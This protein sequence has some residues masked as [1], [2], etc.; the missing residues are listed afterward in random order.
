MDASEAETKIYEAGFKKEKAEKIQNHG[1]VILNNKLLPAS[2]INDDQQTA[3]LLFSDAPDLYQEEVTPEAEEQCLIED[4]LDDATTISLLGVAANNQDTPSELVKYVRKMKEIHETPCLIQ[5]PAT[6]DQTDPQSTQIQHILSPEKTM[7]S[8]FSLSLRIL[9]LIILASIKWKRSI[10]QNLVLCKF[11]T[12]LTSGLLRP[13]GLENLLPMI[14]EKSSIKEISHDWLRSLNP[15]LAFSGQGPAWQNICKAWDTC[16]NKDVLET[17]QDLCLTNRDAGNRLS[18]LYRKDLPSFIRR[19]P[20]MKFVIRKFSLILN[21]IQITNL[22]DQTKDIQRVTSALIVMEQLQSDFFVKK[23]GNSY[24][25]YFILRD[26]IKCYKYLIGTP[27]LKSLFKE[28][29]ENRNHWLPANLLDKGLQ[30]NPSANIFNQEPD[31]HTAIYR[32]IPHN[33][34]IIDCIQTELDFTDSFRC[35]SVF[36]SYILSHELKLTFPSSFIQRMTIQNV[37]LPGIYF[38]RSRFHNFR[39]NLSSH[40]KN[41]RDFLISQGINPCPL[42]IS[43]FSSLAYSFTNE[44]HQTV[45]A[46]PRQ[47][48]LG[49]H[50][51]Y[52]KIYLELESVVRILQLKKLVKY[53]RKS[54]LQC[55]KQL[56]QTLPDHPGKTPEH[57]ILRMNSFNSAIMVDLLP[58]IKI[59]TTINKKSTRNATVLNCH[60]LLGVDVATKFSSFVIINSR[61]S[62]DI[63]NGLSALC[64]KIGKKAT[65]FFSDRESSIVSLADN[66]RWIK[67]SNGIYA[68]DIIIRF[69]PALAESHSRAGLVE[70]RVGAIKRSLGSLD[71][72]SFNLVDLNI[73]LEMLFC[74]LNSIPIYSK[75]LASK[76]HIF[77]NIYTK[78]INPNQLQGR[79][80]LFF[81]DSDSSETMLE[82]RKLYTEMID[83]TAWKTWVI[84][85]RDTDLL[86]QKVEELKIGSIVLFRKTE[87][88]FGPTN[89]FF[90]GVLVSIS[91]PSSDGVSRS[92]YIQSYVE[93]DQIHDSLEEKELPRLYIY[94]RKISDVILIENQEEKLAK[95]ELLKPKPNDNAKEASPASTNHPREE[96]IQTERRIMTRSRRKNEG[97]ALSILLVLNKTELSAAMYTNP[98]IVSENT[99]FDYVQIILYLLLV[100]GIAF[101]LLHHMVKKY[102]LNTFTDTNKNQRIKSFLSTSI[103]RSCSDFLTRSRATPYKNLYTIPLCVILH[104]TCTALGFDKL[105]IPSRKQDIL[106]WAVNQLIQKHT[107]EIQK[108]FSTKVKEIHQISTSA[109]HRVSPSIYLM[110]FITC[111]CWEMPNIFKCF[112]T[113]NETPD[114]YLNASA[115]PM[116][117]EPR[118]KKRKA[119]QPPIKSDSSKKSTKKAASKTVSLP[120]FLILCLTYTQTHAGR[121]MNMQHGNRYPFHTPST[122]TTSTLPQQEYLQIVTEEFTATP[123]DPSTTSNE[124]LPELLEYE[125]VPQEESSSSDPIWDNLPKRKIAIITL[126][127]GLCSL[128]LTNLLIATCCLLIC[129]SLI[130]RWKRRNLKRKTKRVNMP[131]R[132]SDVHPEPEIEENIY[133]S[134]NRKKM[135]ISRPINLHPWIPMA[136]HTSIYDVPRDS[137]RSRFTEI[138]TNPP[139]SILN[140]DEIETCLPR[141]RDSYQHTSHPTRYN[142]TRVNKYQLITLSLISILLIPGYT[143]LPSNPNI[144]NSLADDIMN[145]DNNSDMNK[146]IT[147][148]EVKKG[149]L[150]NI[151]CTIQEM[152]MGIVSW[153]LLDKIEP[154]QSSQI[155]EVLILH[156]VSKPTRVKCIVEKHYRQYE[157]EFLIK[158]STDHENP[159]TAIPE[160][161]EAYSCSAA[162]S[163]PIMRLSNA[164]TKDCNKQDF[165]TYIE[166]APSD[167]ILVTRNRIKK[168]QV[169]QCSVFIHNKI[170]T[171]QKRIAGGFR[172][173]YKGNVPI[174]TEDCLDLHRKGSLTLQ[175]GSDTI[176]FTQ[177][178][179]DKPAYEVIFLSNSSIDRTLPSNPCHVATKQAYFGPY[180]DP[181]EPFQYWDH[182][183]GNR[184]SYQK[185]LEFVVM[186]DIQIS[187]DLIPGILNYKENSLA[188]PRMG[189]VLK[190]NSTNETVAWSSRKFGEIAFEVPEEK[191]SGFQLASDVVQGRIFID[192]SSF[193]QKPNIAVL[194]VLHDTKILALQINKEVNILDRALCKSTHVRDLFLCPDLLIGSDLE[195]NPELVQTIGSQPNLIQQIN[196]A[197]S[198]ASILHHICLNRHAILSISLNDFPTQGSSPFQL[199]KGIVL[200][201]RGEESLIFQCKQVLVEPVLSKLDFCTQEL[202]VYIEVNK[203]KEIR[204]LTPR[205]RILIE[206]P[207]VTMCNEEFPIRF[208]IDEY[209]SICQEGSGKSIKICSS[210]DLLDPTKGLAEARLTTLLQ[211][212]NRLSATSLVSDMRQLVQSEILASNYHKSLD[213]AV[214]YNRRACAG[215]PILCKKAFLQPN[216]IRRELFRQSLSLIS[217]LLN[218]TTYQLLVLVGTLWSLVAICSGLIT[219]LIRLKNLC[220][221]RSTKYHF[222][223]LIVSIIC[224]LD[225]ALNPMSLTRQ[226]F[227]QRCD[228]LTIETQNQKAQIDALTQINK[229][230]MTRMTALEQRFNEEK[231]DSQDTEPH[232]LS[233]PTTRKSYA[234]IKKTIRPG[235]LRRK[236]P[237]YVTFGVTS[238]TDLDSKPELTF[239]PVPTEAELADLGMSGDSDEN[240]SL[241]SDSIAGSEH[242]EEVV[243][244]PDP[245]DVPTQKPR[246]IKREPPYP[247]PTLISAERSTTSLPR[248]EIQS[249]RGRTLPHK[250]VKKS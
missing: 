234:T 134:M 227:K 241:L 36:L 47:T 196:A 232:Y 141:S 188:I 216:D 126:I 91:T 218:S 174:S 159:A 79:V 20:K 208:Y 162:D 211:E 53:I 59:R 29:L 33:I 154:P 8:K 210:P 37:N 183:T 102:L 83:Q 38:L 76:K 11:K 250:Q 165:K 69:I 58:S 16:S 81:L 18:I 92:V 203:V 77:D 121:S 195:S 89:R 130:R 149:G 71:L 112:Y 6:P 207:T 140:A 17:R 182:I 95:E 248:E 139:G 185:A 25:S 244:H 246:L 111:V 51:G 63:Q 205:K 80:P 231:P 155:G 135:S 219:F 225:T 166:E 39:N 46:L 144:M 48:T 101:I 65:T 106:A 179:I 143:A 28:V 189:K 87:K 123:S 176:K 57:R 192:N 19:H 164:K 132:K 157:Q 117:P 238:L 114:P 66:A 214:I 204:Y 175:L 153:I 158:V 107:S 61:N 167:F 24:L 237:K 224:E 229:S 74:N 171:C 209:T 236:K 15:L 184:Y 213:A 245:F 73:F 56:Q 26:L 222:C 161:I 128:L 146:D 160:L 32:N 96:E 113:K 100:G 235:I 201:D 12:D 156:K 180:V 131:P 14:T 220:H 118:K 45:P 194:S 54:C 170:A 120:T 190:Y 116:E 90:L 4:I 198:T 85:N 27:S 206:N 70:S 178:S 108:Q 150:I 9:F 103:F 82:K 122:T 193:P 99:M 127:T 30:F 138:T 240:T 152:H 129:K 75:I 247:A 72:G 110:V 191:N 88:G 202:A 13:S 168:V 125:K 145:N 212:E 104:C 199:S 86:D 78:N 44:I 52:T 84:L 21:L 221:K 136:Q 10:S 109:T 226:K 105:S 243:I 147:V 242:M 3:A 64:V 35:L 169:K 60:I 137:G 187:V 142:Q 41:Y 148:L 172:T 34:S 228:L 124:P 2:A 119:P 249:S 217:F 22:P 23:K 31:K 197:E 1:H 239:P 94:H 40:D 50:M 177:I 133:V 55:K 233:L 230:L 43:P 163:N 93:T 68:G 200:I 215:D 151:H 5:I 97:P 223:Q 181:D 42:V 62:V 49:S 67:Y 173:I 98:K 186:A 7:K 115:P